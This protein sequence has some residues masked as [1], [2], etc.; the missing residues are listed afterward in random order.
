MTENKK[1][2]QLVDLHLHSQYSSK[3][4]E[5][6]VPKGGY[7][8][9]YYIMKL[10]E[11]NVRAFSFTDHDTF[12]HK[13]YLELKEVIDSLPNFKMSI[14]PGVEFRIRSVGSKLGDC[15]FIF[16]NNLNKEKLLKLNVL[17][18]SI[19]QRSTGADIKNLIKNIEA[20]GFDFFIIPDVGKSGKSSFSIYQDVIKHIKYVE[21][22]KDFV[23]SKNIQNHL[24]IDFKH[25]FFSDC[26]NIENYAK[27]PSQTKIEVP[28][29]HEITFDDLKSSLI[30]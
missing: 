4:G 11:N 30:F 22:R 10:K 20:A 26:H 15:N 27:K 2:D 19:A 23:F 8:P 13:F 12:S 25:A 6:Q 18:S 28:I 21:A 24:N 5:K 17:V 7:R 3:A 9:D 29:D 16:N 14:F 1:L